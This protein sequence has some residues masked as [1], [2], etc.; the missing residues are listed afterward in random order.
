MNMSPT[1]S[2][3]PLLALMTT[4][5]MPRGVNVTVPY[6]IRANASLESLPCAKRKFAELGFAFVEEADTR[7]A[8][9]QRMTSR[10]T[11]TNNQEVVRLYLPGD[12]DAQVLELTLGIATGPGAMGPGAMAMELLTL[13]FPSPQSKKEA[14]RDWH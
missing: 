3:L 12:G 14:T 4:A 1:R 10:G 13:T 7:Q 9:G 2:W 8:L 6:R 11:R 5:C